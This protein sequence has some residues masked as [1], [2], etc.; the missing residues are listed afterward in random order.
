MKCTIFVVLSKKMNFLG[1]TKTCICATFKYLYFIQM[2]Q[3]DAN[4]LWIW[5]FCP[6]PATL[7]LLAEEIN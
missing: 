4:Y 3:I 7:I 5:Q 2:K 6:G 1:Q